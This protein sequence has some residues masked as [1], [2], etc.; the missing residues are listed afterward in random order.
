ISG[1]AIEGSVLTASSVTTG[2]DE[3]LTI[4]YQWQNSTDGTTWSN[5]ATGGTSATYTLAE[6][7]E[8]KF[9]RV[10]ETFTDDTSQSVTKTSAASSAVADKAPSV[11]VA[12]SKAGSVLT[13]NVS[14]TT[15]TE[16]DL[17]SYTYVWHSTNNGGQQDTI[18]QNGG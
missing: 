17:T 16:V 14:T 12:I 5:V 4:T 15:P 3:A 8:N 7:D 18:V 2:S 11:S 6:A 9:V 1:S 10:Q 13:A